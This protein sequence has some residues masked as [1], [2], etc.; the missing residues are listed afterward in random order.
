V[1]ADADTSTQPL[2]RIGELSRRTGVGI[3]RLRSWE[4]RYGLL[5]PAR[6]PGGFRLYSATDERRV[7][8]LRDQLAAGVSA[9]EA[10]R[11][12]LAA[13]TP[14]GP[15]P[16]RPFDLRRDELVAALTGFDA[17]RAALMLDD[18]FA[19]LGVEAALATTVFPALREIGDGWAEARLLVGQEHFASTLLEGRLLSLL[20]D[21]PASHGPLA[22]LACASG[23]AHTL[24]L[25]ALGIALRNRGW[26]IAYLGADT[27]AA[28]IQ[29]AA[30]RIDPA[31]TVISATM[32]D[33]LAG[34]LD[35][36]R[37][38]ARNANLALAGPG[39]GRVLA[40][41]VGARLLEG[42]PFAAAAAVARPADEIAA[43]LPDTPA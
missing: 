6:T 41:R 39:A 12:I 28:D 17:A 35:G 37:E 26:R 11:A 30:A 15:A 19:A 10:A 18:V 2:I 34:T 3:D 32:G 38:L 36:V 13:G 22:L 8:A 33:R 31:I 43:R 5:N 16:R 27:P 24:G 23:E 14:R 29:Q 42:D 1:F 40:D 7:R 21:R 25:I 20:N 9:A 4:R